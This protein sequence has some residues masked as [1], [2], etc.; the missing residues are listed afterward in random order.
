MTMLRA[1][2][3]D[4][5]PGQTIYG[6]RVPTPGEFSASNVKRGGCALSDSAVRIRCDTRWPGCFAIDRAIH[7]HHGVQDR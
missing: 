2:I 7:N 1:A 6:L 4:D 5:L 3:P